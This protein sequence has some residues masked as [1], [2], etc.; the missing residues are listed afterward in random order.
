MLETE[1]SDLLMHLSSNYTQL[2]KHLFEF[3]STAKLT[4][5]PKVTL[6]LV[7]KYIPQK[8]KKW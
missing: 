8:S 4:R 6:V 2:T 3:M 1:V 7:P 5:A